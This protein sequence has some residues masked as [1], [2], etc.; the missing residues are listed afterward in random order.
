MKPVE[1]FLPQDPE[2]MPPSRVPARVR[3]VGEIIL[4]GGLL[5][6]ALIYVLAPP[7]AAPVLMDSRQYD[8]QV[9]RLGGQTGLL[10]VHFNQ[11]LDSL[12]H[13]ERLAYTIG[14]LAIVVGLACFKIAAMIAEAPAFSAPQFHGDD[15]NKGA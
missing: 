8:Y 1:P 2:P 7:E 3:L 12:W 4:I 10:M 9:Q 11:W 14:A 6:A 13:G 5:G 15:A